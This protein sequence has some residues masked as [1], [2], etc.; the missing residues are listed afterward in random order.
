MD[1]GPH[2]IVCFPGNCGTRSSVGGIGLGVA[3]IFPV[4]LT[5]GA[6]LLTARHQCEDYRQSDP[7]RR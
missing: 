2:R 5:D 7:A 3:V 1:F 6:T 4:M